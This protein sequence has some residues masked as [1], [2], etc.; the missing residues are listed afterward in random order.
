MSVPQIPFYIFSNY[1]CYGMF[2]FYEQFIKRFLEQRC[3]K[4]CQITFAS[5]I[6]DINFICIPESFDKNYSHQLFDY[7]ITLVKN[8]FDSG[9]V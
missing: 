8:K 9:K 4:I 1:R 7:I 3:L 5:I 6:I 2:V